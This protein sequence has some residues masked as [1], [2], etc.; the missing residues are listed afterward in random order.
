MGDAGRQEVGESDSGSFLKGQD[1][2]GILHS[3]GKN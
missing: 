2:T 1:L 3:S